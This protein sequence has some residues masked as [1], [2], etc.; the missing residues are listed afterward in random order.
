MPFQPG[1]SGN[2][3]GRPKVKPFADALKRALAQGD[4]ERLRKLA[5]ALLN[6]AAEGDMPAIKEVADRLDGKVPQAIVGD[7]SFDPVRLMVTPT[8]ANL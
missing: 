2:P 5:E 4:P 6:K 8:D 3:S 1:Q 7:D